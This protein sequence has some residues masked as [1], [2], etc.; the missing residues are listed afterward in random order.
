MDSHF[1]DSSKRCCSTGVI[2]SIIYNDC[3]QLCSQVESR[4][5]V[6]M[7]ISH[8]NCDQCCIVHF[9]MIETMNM[10]HTGK[11]WLVDLT[12][13]YVYNWLQHRLVCYNAAL[14]G[15]KYDASLEHVDGDFTASIDT[16]PVLNNTTVIGFSL[17]Q[18]AICVGTLWGI[19][20]LGLFSVLRK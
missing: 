3:D 18:V 14:S 12:V 8:I 13:R 5:K 16:G 20:V 10:V 17:L 4:S 2:T 7:V 1:W 9:T 6:S 11:L 15:E 19:F